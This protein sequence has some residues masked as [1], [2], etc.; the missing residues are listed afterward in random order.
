MNGHTYLR[1]YRVLMLLGIFS[2]LGT[3]YIYT[4]PD[5]YLVE[6]YPTPNSGAPR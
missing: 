2:F 6:E 4:I 3:A 5:D 1:N